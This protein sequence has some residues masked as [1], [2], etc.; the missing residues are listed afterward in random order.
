MF[1]MFCNSAYISLLKNLRGIIFGGADEG[2]GE[3]IKWLLKHFRYRELGVPPAL[4][5]K[6]PQR[7]KI[8]HIEYPFPDCEQSIEVLSRSADANFS[9]VES[10]GFS[11]IFA[12]PLLLLSQKSAEMVRKFALYVF[13]AEVPEND[14]DM[15][16]NIR[17][18]DYAMTDLYE[19]S[20]EQANRVL[21]GEIKVEDAIISRRTMAKE[22]G[23]KRFWRLGDG[24]QGK[25]FVLYL[26]LFPVIMKMD[27]DMKNCPLT[28]IVPAICVQKG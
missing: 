5:D 15:K 16:R 8:R 19:R 22:D 25:P 4:W 21:S 17:L 1:K 28:A 13:R 27:E 2:E 24:T 7:G 14:R 10:I 26:D 6:I 20:V 18:C 23:R 12:A 11:S 3:S 9:V